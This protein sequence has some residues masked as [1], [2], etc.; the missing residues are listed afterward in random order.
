MSRYGRNEDRLS[1]LLWGLGMVFVGTVIL[2]Q[3]LDLLSF[4]VWREWWPLVIVAIGIGQVVASRTA[5]GIGD[6]VSMVLMGGWFYVAANQIWDLSW[7]NSWPL[8]LVA[9]GMGM[10][11]RSIAAGFIGRDRDAREERNDG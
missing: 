8:A 7:R 1:G 6:G 2:L 11:V 9:V 4:R 3:Y 5:K 10:V